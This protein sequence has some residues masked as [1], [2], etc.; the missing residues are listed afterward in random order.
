M[1]TEPC[2]AVHLTLESKSTETPAG[3]AG[4]QLPAGPAV[5]AAAGQHGAARARCTACRPT[6]ISGSSAG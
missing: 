3:R 5:A 2:P 4:A 1:R 6:V